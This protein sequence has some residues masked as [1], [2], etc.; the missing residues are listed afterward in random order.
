M[1]L[2]ANDNSLIKRRGNNV[3]DYKAVSSYAKYR[4]TDVTDTGNGYGY[5]KNSVFVDYPPKEPTSKRVVLFS[6]IDG[7]ALQQVWSDPL[8]GQYEFKFIA[9]R[10]P[11]LIFTYD[12]DEN[13]N[14]VIMGP[15]YPTLMPQ[16]EGIVKP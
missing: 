3:L 8:T 16:F 10:K 7:K 11:Y 13:Y 1:K 15:V 4:L 14:A 6:I 12:S 5:F 9:L 2:Q